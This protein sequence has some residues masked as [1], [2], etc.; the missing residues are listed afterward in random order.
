MPGCVFDIK[1]GVG[2]ETSK[3]KEEKL[4]MQSQI[5]KLKLEAVHKHVD[6]N[7]SNQIPA[8]FVVW[9][10]FGTADREVAMAATNQI[11]DLDITAKILRRNLE[12]LNSARSLALGCTV[13]TNRKCV[14]GAVGDPLTTAQIR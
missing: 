4:L 14:V 10:L 2:S 11:T 5:Q 13:N 8:T 9:C 3:M 1:D 6:S 12:A 7:I